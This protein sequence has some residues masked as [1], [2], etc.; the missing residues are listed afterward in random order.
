MIST[1]GTLWTNGAFGGAL[2]ALTLKRHEKSD[3]TSLTSVLFLN[4][5]WTER[6]RSSSGCESLSMGCIGVGTKEQE[7]S[8]WQYW[9]EMM[10]IY[11]SINC[12]Y[13]FKGG[14]HTSTNGHLGCSEG[15][16]FNEYKKS[17]GFKPNSSGREQTHAAMEA[18]AKN[19]IN[20]N[21]RNFMTSM[22]VFFALTNLKKKKN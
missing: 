20:L 19:L 4:T 6:L 15:F 21:Y 9:S 8:E 3:C 11:W 2:A 14:R 5:C 17:I 7:V 10:N 1:E 22:K 16:N 12:H 18:S 13:S